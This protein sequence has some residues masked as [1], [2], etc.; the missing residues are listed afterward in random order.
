VEQVSEL[1]DRLRRSDIELAVFLT[2]AGVK[3]LFQEADRLGQG[4]VLGQE[5]RKVTTVCR[6]PKPAAALKSY[7][8]APSVNIASPFTSTELLARLAEVELTGRSVALVHYGERALEVADALRSRGA[9][10]Y[11]LC[12]YEWALPEDL[13]PLRGLVHDLILGRFA[14]VAFTSQV[15]V[16][17]LFRVAHE[18]GSAERLR[19]ALTTRV[20]VASVGPTCRA[21]AEQFG[22]LSHV[23]P[24]QPKMGPMVEALAAYL[25]RS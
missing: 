21:A 13:S 6:G 12:L 8:V 4:E 2:G 16:R 3:A 22:V 25:A 18:D 7:G 11:E 17:H 14:A 15:Q 10:L 5:L 1:L 24:A 20:V 9:R 19:E 23:M